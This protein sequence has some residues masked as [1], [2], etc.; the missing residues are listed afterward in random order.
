MKKII[1]VL[2]LV[3]YSSISCVQAET[4]EELQVRLE[5]N[6]QEEQKKVDTQIL[7]KD[8]V[9][10]SRKD[11]HSVN[12]AIYFYNERDEHGEIASHQAINIA[13]Y[14]ALNGNKKIYY[15]QVAVDA[16]DSNHIRTL[17]N[18]DMFSRPS[19]RPLYVY[20][21]FGK[22]SVNFLTDDMRIGTV[23]YGFGRY[24]NNFSYSTISG[25]QKIA[26]ILEVEYYT[27]KRPAFLDL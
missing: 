14:P 17:A 15:F 16:Q 19:G 1:F 5:N 12:D 9:I 6:L 4:T 3:I 21:H 23:L 8:T 2:M 27:D 11:V 13:S 26:P 10:K 18:L 7:K 25:E 20:L 22:K 24:S